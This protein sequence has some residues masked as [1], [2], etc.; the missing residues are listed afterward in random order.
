MRK[1]TYIAVFEPI[2][3]GGYSVYFPDV[4]GCISCGDNLTYAHAMASEALGLHLYALEKKG[5]PFPPAAETPS[6]ERETAE[7]FLVSPVTVYP[8]IVKNDL[9]NRA[10]KT[11]VTL[12]AWLKELAEER[13]VNYSKL[14]Q[15]ALMDYLNIQTTDQLNA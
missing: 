15:A 8:D 13:G 4:P 7:G 12:P 9:D 11:N 6:I 3:V 5:E 2:P 14:F 1:V 10:V